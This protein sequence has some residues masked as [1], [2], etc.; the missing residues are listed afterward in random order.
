MVPP[1]APSFTLVHC[2]TA[3]GLTAGK[4]GLQPPMVRARVGV[5]RTQRY[6]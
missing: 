4:A 2:S 3:L 1:R 5:E 6:E